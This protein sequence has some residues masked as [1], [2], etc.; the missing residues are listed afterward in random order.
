MNNIIYQFKGAGKLLLV[1]ILALGAL[2]MWVL[3][4]NRHFS[5][6]IVPDDYSVMAVNSDQRDAFN[7][8][9]GQ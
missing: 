1:I 3:K 2:E 7:Q 9:G 5:V 6:V 4:D 8:F